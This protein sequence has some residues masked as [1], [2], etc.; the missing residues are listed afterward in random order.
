M[1]NRVIKFRVWNIK[2]R[3]FYYIKFGE[4]SWFGGGYNKEK[5]TYFWNIINANLSEN[6]CE[7]KMSLF[8]DCIIQQF[9]G[10]LDKNNKEIY[11]GD[12]IEIENKNCEIIWQVDYLSF[13]AK[14]KHTFYHGFYFKESQ[15]VGNIF[16]NS[17]LLK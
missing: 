8:E 15:I 16:E 3:E 1:N 11:E 10:L 14:N 9:T 12:I 17:E 7:I 13:I 6:P 2:Y 4:F 5:R